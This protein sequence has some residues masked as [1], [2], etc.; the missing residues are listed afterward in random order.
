MY[1]RLPQFAGLFYPNNPIELKKLINIYLQEVNIKDFNFKPK[2]LIVPHAGYTYS[3]KIAAYG[4]KTLIGFNYQ[5]IILIGPSHNFI[6]KGLAVAPSGKWLTPLGEVSVLG[7]D[8][9]VKVKKTDKTS[10]LIE[11]FKI[12]EKEH[13]LEVQIPFLQTVLKDFQITP[14]LTGEVNN[15]LAVNLIDSILDDNTLLIISS[16]LSHYY[17]YNEAKRL[18]QIT[19]DAVLRYD[20]T[21]LNNFGEACGI[22]GI[23]ILLLIAKKNN[24]KVKLLKAANSGDTSGMKDQVVG[25]SSFVFYKD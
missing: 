3:G 24:W 7:I 22:K 9:F 8:A 17:S 14:I 13:S 15:D 6:F 23:E 19:I 25:Y 10:I 18:D 21:K 4:Y 2:A 12:H 16:D 20:L 5:N 11:S 1:L